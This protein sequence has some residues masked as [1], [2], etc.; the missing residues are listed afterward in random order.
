MRINS[1]CAERGT[2]KVAAFVEP[3]TRTTAR[4]SHARSP[5]RSRHSRVMRRV[6]AGTVAVM[7]TFVPESRM[8]VMAAE[9]AAA[10]DD[11]EAATS[12]R[13]TKNSPIPRHQFV[14]IT[15]QYLTMFNPAPVKE[16][17]KRRFVKIASDR[18]RSRARGEL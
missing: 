8:E 6:P 7:T 14:F 1:I 12:K 16:G 4:G 3:P 5:N 10:V 11:E 17:V 9:S 18:G 13:R 15:T 2:E